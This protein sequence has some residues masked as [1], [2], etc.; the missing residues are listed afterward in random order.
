MFSASFY[1]TIF[2]YI[3]KPTV[4][5]SVFN[6]FIFRYGFRFCIGQ[7]ICFFGI[8]RSF[9]CHR[10][11]LQFNTSKLLWCYR[12]NAYDSHNTPASGNV[13]TC[14]M[15][16][17]KKDDIWKVNITLIL[18]GLLWPWVCILP[19]GHFQ[20]FYYFVKNLNLSHPPE[21]PK[22]TDSLALEHKPFLG[23]QLPNNWIM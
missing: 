13:L 11:T 21:I 3:N 6:L 15:I 19:M 1:F 4:P 7:L 14:K 10:W 8:F 23:K 22:K 18:I 16:F 17:S 5:F 12:S 9:W 20:Q 2:C